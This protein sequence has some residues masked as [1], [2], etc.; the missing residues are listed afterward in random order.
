MR[1]YY[2]LLFKGFNLTVFS[3]RF[4]NSIIAHS[5]SIVISLYQQLPNQ[6]NHLSSFKVNTKPWEKRARYVSVKLGAG[7]GIEP[8]IFSLWGWW[9]TF[10]LSCYNEDFSFENL[11]LKGILDYLQVYFYLVYSVTSNKDRESLF[12]MKRGLFTSTDSITSNVMLRESL[13]EYSIGLANP[14]NPV[15]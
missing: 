14:K 15:H 2:Q 4:W 1:W 10:T 5:E 6:L 11:I 13:P 7:D 9:V 8:T 12:L 3:L